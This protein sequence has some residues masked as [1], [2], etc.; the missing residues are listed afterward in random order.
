MK[1]EKE[2]IYNIVTTEGV[3]LEVSEAEL[4]ELYKELGKIVI[5]SNKFAPATV[6][7][8]KDIWSQG[9]Y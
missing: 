6:T 4:I 1:I 2:V 9:E 8:R 3:R 7:V 5:S